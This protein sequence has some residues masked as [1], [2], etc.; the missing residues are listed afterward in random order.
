MSLLTW[1]GFGQAVKE[2]VEASEPTAPKKLAEKP[3]VTYY[4]LGLTDRNR[5]SLRIGYSEVTMNSVGVQNLINQLELYKSQIIDEP[6]TE[7][8]KEE[9]E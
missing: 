4:S 6:T 5:I 8:F 1:L 9:S 7:T 2:G 3:E